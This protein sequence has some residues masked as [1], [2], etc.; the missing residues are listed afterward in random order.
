M[1]A[2]PSVVAAAGL[3][4]LLLLAADPASAQ[5][6]AFEA[7]A[8]WFIGSIARGVAMVAV[9]V[10]G[11]AAWFL[12]ASLRMVGLVVGGGLIIANVDTIVGWMGF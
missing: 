5:A 7:G 6:N 4:A 10:L 9:V 8:N 12:S 11:I 2:T 3:A 1:K